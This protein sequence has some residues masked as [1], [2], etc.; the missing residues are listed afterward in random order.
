L[1]NFFLK[2]EHFGELWHLQ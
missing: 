2:L 1:Y